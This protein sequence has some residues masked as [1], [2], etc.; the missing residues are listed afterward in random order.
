M[1]EWC[2][3]KS[4]GKIIARKSICIAKKCYLLI[5]EDEAGNVAYHVRLKGQPHVVIQGECNLQYG[6]DIEAMY[7]DL[8]NEVPVVMNHSVQPKPDRCEPRAVFK[9]N[10]DHRVYSVSMCRT[11]HFPLHREDPTQIVLAN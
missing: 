5:L 10:K 7:M 1:L 6:G 8:Y 3:T 2:S 4:V 9:T 11:S